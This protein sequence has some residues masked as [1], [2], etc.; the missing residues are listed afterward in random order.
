VQVAGDLEAR[1]DRD[2]GLEVGRLLGRVERRRGVE[3]RDEAQAALLG[4]V[5]RAP[6]GQAFEGPAGRGGDQAD[7]VAALDV[8]HAGALGRRA[9]LEADAGAVRFHGSHGDPQ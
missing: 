4:A 5:H 6:D 7:D 2:H 3:E 8:L 1:E 9:A